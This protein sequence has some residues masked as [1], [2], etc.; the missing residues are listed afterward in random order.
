MLLHFLHEAAVHMNELLAAV[1][2]Q[3]EV[4]G[5]FLL[6]HKLV[7]GAGAVPGEPL[8]YALIRKLRQSAVHGGF[9]DGDLPADDNVLCGEAA[10]P[11]PG[12]EL[13]DL[14]ALLC[15]IIVPVQ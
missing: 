10:P 13:Y 9:A 7:A 15:I 3:V 6:V 2:F 1:A 14:I 4:G 12:K 11:V 8:Q 5:A